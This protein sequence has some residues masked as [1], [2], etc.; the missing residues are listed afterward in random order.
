MPTQIRRVVI[1]F[2]QST[3]LNVYLIYTLTDI[4]RNHVQP[5]TSQN[6]VM[7]IQKINQH[8]GPLSCSFS[9]LQNRINTEKM[10]QQGV[11]LQ[12]SKYLK[13]LYEEAICYIKQ[14]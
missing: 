2:T 1:C 10:S 5:W 6:P 11:S 3:D 12:I 9:T 14:E 4:L 8:S 13:Y 7:L